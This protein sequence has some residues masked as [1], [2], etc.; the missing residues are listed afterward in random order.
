M[1]WRDEAHQLLTTGLP[2]TPNVNAA[3]LLELALRE[4]HEKDAEIKRL[5]HKIA[6]CARRNAIWETHYWWTKNFK[7]RYRRLTQKSWAKV[8]EQLKNQGDIIKRERAEIAELKELLRYQFD[9]IKFCNA[10]DID[11]YKEKKKRIEEILST[12]NE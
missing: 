7:R 12:P 2:T 4:L 11:G 9:I 10:G 5:G 6:D 8:C 3:T 1:N